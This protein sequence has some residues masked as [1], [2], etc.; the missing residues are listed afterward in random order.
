MEGYFGT[1]QRRV[2]HA[3]QVY[4]YARELLAYIEADP[5]LTLSCAYF[6]DIGMHEEDRKQASCDGNWQELDG[7]RVARA[8]LAEIGADDSLTD[9]VVEIIGNHHTAG[10]VDSAEFRI[11]RDADALVN[12]ADALPGKSDEKI[13]EILNN[14]LV[15][16]AG[17]RIGRRLFLRHANRH[18]TMLVRHVLAGIET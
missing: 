11:L 1:D 9:Q 18:R 17:Y 15:T 8:L 12:F 6:H 4:I 5:V 3:L 10:I 7:P 14:Q 2:E 13:E 16:E